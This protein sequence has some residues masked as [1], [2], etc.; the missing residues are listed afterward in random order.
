MISAMATA[1]AGHLWIREA[2]P[3]PAGA[4]TLPLKITL[5]Y[6]QGERTRTLVLE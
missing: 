3:V 6:A 2:S 1:A 5:V 4:G